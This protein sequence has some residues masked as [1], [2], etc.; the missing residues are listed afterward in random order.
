[1]LIQPMLHNDFNVS[2]EIVK[3]SKNKTNTKQN[4]TYFSAR[5]LSRNLQ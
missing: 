1:M 2:L 3:E 5:V 4:K